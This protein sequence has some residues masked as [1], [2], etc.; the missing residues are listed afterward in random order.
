MFWL[1]NVP[2]WPFYNIKMVGE[3]DANCSAML[4]N[5]KKHSAYS[6]KLSYLCSH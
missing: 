5:S 6:K 4:K 2:K 1:Q 3:E